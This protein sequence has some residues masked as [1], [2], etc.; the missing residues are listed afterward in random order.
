MSPLQ[1]IPIRL[2]MQFRRLIRNDHLILTAVAVIV[3]AASAFGT[4][5]IRQSITYIQIMLMDT[6]GQSLA[7]RA[8]SLP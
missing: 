7:E 8:S 3:G 1:I 6:S 4:V 2:L 5:A